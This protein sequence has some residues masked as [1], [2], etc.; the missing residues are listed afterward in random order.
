MNHFYG[1]DGKYLVEVSQDRLKNS[2]VFFYE[3]LENFEG[4]MG[5]FYGDDVKYLA[6]VLQ[7]RLG[8]FKKYVGEI[9][10]KFKEDFVKF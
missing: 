3:I 7:E 9:Y 5:R 1:G 4:I 8:K 2:N 10:E 6:K